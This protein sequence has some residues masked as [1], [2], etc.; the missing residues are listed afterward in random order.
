MQEY[1][2]GSQGYYEPITIMAREYQNGENI[3]ELNRYC[4]FLLNIMIK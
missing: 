2:F 1:L 4:R 3:Y